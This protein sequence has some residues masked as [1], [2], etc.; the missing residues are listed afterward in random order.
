MCESFIV[1]VFFNSLRSRDATCIVILRRNLK[2]SFIKYNLICLF[3][4][5]FSDFV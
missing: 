4:Y 2:I 5:A 3:V 1:V